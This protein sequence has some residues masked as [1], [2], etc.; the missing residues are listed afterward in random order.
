MK[1]FRTFIFG[2]A[3][4]AA[5]VHANNAYRGSRGT[6]TLILN[7]DTRWRYVAKFTPRPLYPGERTPVP[8]EHEAGWAPDPARRFWK[9]GKFLSL[10]GIRHLER[11][12]R[13]LYSVPPKPIST[14]ICLR[15]SRNIRVYH[16]GRKLRI[17][18]VWCLGP[19][20]ETNLETRWNISQCIGHCC[21]DRIIVIPR[22]TSDP[23]N[24]CFG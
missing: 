24:E 23:A 8:T 11:P 14:A 17:V 13:V 12:A 5:P 7:L 9:K 20:P 3:K 21:P 4:K 15:Y 2:K 19:S 22:L 10:T 6:T 1:P 18:A 16:L